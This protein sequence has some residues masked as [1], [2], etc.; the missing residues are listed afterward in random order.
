MTPPMKLYS[1]SQAARET[2]LDRG[3]ISD[4]I[5]KGKI[6]VLLLSKK[7]PKIPESELAR[8]IRENTVHGSAAI[9]QALDKRRNP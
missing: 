9:A 3:T 5:R 7:R 2:R 6:G 4:L 8:W 1:I